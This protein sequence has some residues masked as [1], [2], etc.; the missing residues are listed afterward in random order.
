MNNET[1]VFLWLWS[2]YWIG[3]CLA[4]GVRWMAHRDLQALREI[5]ARRDGAP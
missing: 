3:R 1:Q 4:A 2:A 5:T